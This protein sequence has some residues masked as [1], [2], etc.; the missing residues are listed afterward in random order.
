MSV[1]A[2]LRKG[3]CGI[4]LND[5]TNSRN[6]FPDGKLTDFFRIRT[7]PN[8]FNHLPRRSCTGQNRYSRLQ[9]FTCRIKKSH[10]RSLHKNETTNRVCVKFDNAVSRELYYIQPPLT[11]AHPTTNRVYLYTS[12]NTIHPPTYTYV[13][14]L[15]SSPSLF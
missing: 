3:P 4:F 15:G 6:D 13:C 1:T 10:S 14:R 7:Y 11:L 8:A 5:Q 2:K 9:K 12:L